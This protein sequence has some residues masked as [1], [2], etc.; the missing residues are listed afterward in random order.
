MASCGIACL[1]SRKT[2]SRECCAAARP[3]RRSRRSF[4]STWPANGKATKSIRRGSW[5]RRGPCTRS[6]ASPN[7]VHFGGAGDRFMSPANAPRTRQTTKCD[8]LPHQSEQHC[9]SPGLQRPLRPPARVRAVLHSAPQPVDFAAIAFR[10]LAAPQPF[11]MRRRLALFRQLQPYLPARLR[12]TVKR[13]RNRRRAAHLTESQ[14]LH[15]KV[16]AVVLHLQHVAGSDFARRFGSLSV[17]L[18]LAQ[19]TCPS[20]Q[21]A[22]LEES[23]GPKPL[24]H[25]H[26]SHHPIFVPLVGRLSA[27]TGL[28]VPPPSGRVNVRA[29]LNVAVTT[30]DTAPATTT[31][32]LTVPLPARFAGSRTFTWSSPVKPGAGPAYDAARVWFP[33]VTVTSES[34]PRFWMPVPK[35]SSADWPELTSSGIPSQLPAPQGELKISTTVC[36]PFDWFVTSMAAATAVP[37]WFAANTAG[38]TEFSTT[39]LLTGPEGVSMVITAGPKLALSGISA[40]ICEGPA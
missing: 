27:R 2:T 3:M 33:I 5:R 12:L 19:F 9:G 28:P 17:G 29:Y 13:L 31:V 24:V 32:I 22:C 18:N 7:T 39:G 4:A 8:G 16:A 14:Y 35:S 1:P 30:F 21:H 20:R 36:R 11:E 40:L 23:G 38:A 26:A 10:W 15:L 34:E 6:A 25:S 37:L